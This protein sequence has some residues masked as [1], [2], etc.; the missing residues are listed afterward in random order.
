MRKCKFDVP[1]TPSA[2][3]MRQNLREARLRSIPLVGAASLDLLPAPS[4]EE[5]SGCEAVVQSKSSLLIDAALKRQKIIVLAVGGQCR[6]RNS[7]SG[8]CLAD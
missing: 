3:E 7:F 2:R 6:Y 8:F 5:V 1:L 4:G